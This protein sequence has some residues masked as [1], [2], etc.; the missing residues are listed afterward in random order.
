MCHAVHPPILYLGLRGSSVPFAFATAALITGRLGEGWLGRD[1]SLDRCSRGGFSRSA[2]CSRVVELRGDGVGRLLELGPRRE[3][4]VSPWLTG[5]AYIHSVMVQERRGMLRVWNLS[6]LCATF[7]LTILETFLTP[8]GRTRLRALFSGKRTSGLG[9]SRSCGLVVAV[10]I[11]LIG[12]RGD[13]LR[14]PG[15]IDSRSPRAA[16]RVSD[17]QPAVRARTALCVVGTVRS[18]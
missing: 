15:T 4:G 12:W 14:S 7:S 10:T 17:K 13:R 16:T 1:P 2:L 5:T 18:F 11:A 9:C 8:I 3:R 6:L